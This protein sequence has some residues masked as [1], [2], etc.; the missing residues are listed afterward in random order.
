M[1]SSLFVANQHV[2]DGVLLVQGVIDVEN[3]A[4]WVTPHELHVF[5]LEAADQDV[6]AIE[7]FGSVALRHV[8]DE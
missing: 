8:H 7:D 5:C 3:G 4:T 1:H 2:L 6:R